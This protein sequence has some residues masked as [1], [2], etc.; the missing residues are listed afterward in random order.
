MNAFRRAAQRSGWLKWNELEGVLRD[1]DGK[2]MRW[3]VGTNSEKQAG[4]RVS[5]ANIRDVAFIL[6]AEASTGGC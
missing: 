3:G 2:V 5:E 4:S 1:E 6:F